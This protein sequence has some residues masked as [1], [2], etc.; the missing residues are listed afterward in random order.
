[1]S[2]SIP[3]KHVQEFAF[4]IEN[5]QPLD[6]VLSNNTEAIWTVAN[7][8]SHPINA[9]NQISDTIF[10]DPGRTATLVGTTLRLQQMSGVTTGYVVGSQYS[11]SLAPAV[12]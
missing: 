3:V 7:H 1:M 11:Y 6:F 5:N 12:R 8:G 10:I 4:T 9:N 2:K